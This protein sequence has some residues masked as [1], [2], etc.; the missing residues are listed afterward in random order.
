M[1][2]T[3]CCLGLLLPERRK[4]RNLGGD[5]RV[6]NRIGEFA[7][8]GEGAEAVIILAGKLHVIRIEGE[9][10]IDWRVGAH[11]RKGAQ[12]WI[13]GGDAGQLDVFGSREKRSLS[14]EHAEGERQ[15]ERDPAPDVAAQQLFAD[16][17][18][19]EQEP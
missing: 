1:L 10:R 11:P 14:D 12:P 18:A 17:S 7:A 4:V 2:P 15:K 6:F 9:V 8:M 3:G 19:A 5:S 13:V 16:E